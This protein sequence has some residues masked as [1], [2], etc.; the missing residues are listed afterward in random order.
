MVF[1]GPRSLSY[2]YGSPVLTGEVIKTNTSSTS[3][4]NFENSLYRPFYQYFP[5][6]LL[7]AFW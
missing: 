7:F 6:L 3:S 4:S 2:V 5:P 1:D